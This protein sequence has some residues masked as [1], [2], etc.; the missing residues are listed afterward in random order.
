VW[1]G[2]EWGVPASLD[3]REYFCRLHVQ[4]GSQ[5]NV[6]VAFLANSLRENLYQSVT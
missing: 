5:F 4:L 3:W 2:E 1:N 6:M